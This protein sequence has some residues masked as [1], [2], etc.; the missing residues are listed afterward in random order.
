M[1][2]VHCPVWPAFQSTVPVV[3]VAVTLSMK[4]GPGMLASVY[5]LREPDQQTHSPFGLRHGLR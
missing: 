1:A 3:D 5:S 2:N 4:G